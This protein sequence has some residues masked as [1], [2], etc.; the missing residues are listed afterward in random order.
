MIVTRIES[1]TKT[2]FKVYVDEQF[3]F[4]LYKGEL[5]H[6][7]IQEGMEV[8]QALVDTIKKEAISK[9]AKLRAMHLLNDMGIIERHERRCAHG[10]SGS[11]RR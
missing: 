5:S 3:A 1:V 11:D 2:K 9:R 10:L 8:S 6:Y 7:R 4:V